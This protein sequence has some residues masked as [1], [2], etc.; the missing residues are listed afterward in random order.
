MGTFWITKYAKVRH[1][2]ADVNFR[3]VRMPEGTFSHIAAHFISFHHETCLYNI[4][5]LK[6]QFI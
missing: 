3:W 2:Q 6:H 4:D 5:H 1:A